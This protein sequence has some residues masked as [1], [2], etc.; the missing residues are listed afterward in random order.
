MYSQRWFIVVGCLFLTGTCIVV[1]QPT[2]LNHG[3]TPPHQ[4]RQTRVGE[5]L[6]TQKFHGHQYFKSLFKFYPCSSPFPTRRL[7]MK[8]GLY[9][10][11]GHLIKWAATI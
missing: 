8:P 3:K 5:L 4:L 10:V 7:C 9:F 6:T 1:F 2:G 11:I